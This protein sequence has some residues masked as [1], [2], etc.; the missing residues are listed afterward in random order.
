MILRRETILRV[1]DAI[2]LHLLNGKDDVL[3][4]LLVHGKLPGLPK[5]SIAALEVAFKRFLLCMDVHV[6]FEVLGQGK[7][8]E[9]EGANVLLD[10]R[11]RCDVSPEGEASGVRFVAASNLA[12][13]WSFHFLVL[14][15]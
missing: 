2:S 14:L 11:V 12:F 5:S 6:L 10:R 3:V 4:D 1:R 13:V 7:S 15:V 8:L 9:A